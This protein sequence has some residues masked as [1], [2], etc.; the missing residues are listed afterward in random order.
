[1]PKHRKRVPVTEP[2]TARYLEPGQ[3]ILV[4]S[5]RSTSG[6]VTRVTAVDTDKFHGEHVQVDTKTKGRLILSW[7]AEVQRVVA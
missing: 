1:M 3:D 6:T 7:G 5:A 4:F 2:F